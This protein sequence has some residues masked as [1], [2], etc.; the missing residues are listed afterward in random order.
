MKYW[1][2]FPRNAHDQGL[3]NQP[4]LRHTHVMFHRLL[5]LALLCTTPAWLPAEETLT[6]EAIMVEGHKG[7]D[8]LLKRVIA[9]TAT[10]E[11]KA[12]LV[13]LYEALAELTPAKG[14]TD[15]WSEKTALLLSAAQA[16]QSGDAAAVAQLRT[17]SN[18]KACHSLH[19]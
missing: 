6:I 15:S 19:K 10:D 18:C 11:E 13:T 14:E 1:G 7:K 2:G 3:P 12:R 9:G 5:L 4:P 17:A 8:T 16:I